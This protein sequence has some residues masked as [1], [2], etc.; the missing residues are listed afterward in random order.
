MSLELKF[1][2]LLILLSLLPIKI[3]NN[4]NGEAPIEVDKRNLN[5]DISNRESRIFWINNGVPG[6]SRKIIKYSRVE[7]FIN[8]LTLYVY[9]S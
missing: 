1:F 4:I 9:F 3:E 6:T 7:F 2:K 8:L 5:K